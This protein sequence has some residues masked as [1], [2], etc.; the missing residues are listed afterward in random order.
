M[1]VK[2]WVDDL[3]PAP[4]GWVWA[5]SSL[6]AIE[7]LNRWASTSLT[8]EAVSLDHDL[9]ENDSTLAVLDWFTLEGKWPRSIYIHTANPA[10][11]RDLL[12]SA[13][14]N[15]PDEVS[16]IQVWQNSDG[17]MPDM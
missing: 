3:R 9:G 17:S 11:R 7:I 13:D 6:E 12:T 1:D 14:R 4:V 10:G 2:L 16:I 5:K 8:L 15:A